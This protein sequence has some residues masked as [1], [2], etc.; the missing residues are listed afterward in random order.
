MYT[1]VTLGEDWEVADSPAG[2]VHLVWKASSRVTAAT[3]A[4]ASSALD[5]GYVLEELVRAPIEQ[6]EERATRYGWR[7][8]RGV[9]K[10]DRELQ[11]A[12]RYRFLGY[13]GA[14]V[15]T[16]AGDALADAE[17]AAIERLLDSARPAWS[18]RGHV[19]ALVRLW[20]T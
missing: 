12:A 2:S 4:L 10:T 5:P 8:T 18:T 3:F 15:V 14:I 20:E 17:R 11:I 13:A 6:R 7:Y 16:V 9:A 19:D 1:H